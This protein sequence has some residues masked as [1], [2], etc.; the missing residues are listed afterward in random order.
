[1]LF[2]SIDATT[3]SMPRAEHTAAV[4]A[5]VLMLV[6]GRLGIFFAFRKA[7]VVTIKSFCHIVRCS[8]GYKNWITQ[9]D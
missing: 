4:S 8:V 3:Y 6:T 2:I 7:V 9:C 1:M 5:I